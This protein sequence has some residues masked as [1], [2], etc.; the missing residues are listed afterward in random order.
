M[1][2]KRVVIACLLITAF[3]SGIA[4]AD[5]PVPET[6]KIGL[7]FGQS[8]ANIFTLGSET[9]IDI[10]T[11]ENGGYKSLLEVKSPG[12]IKVRRDEY[13]NII[14]GSE[15][16]IDYVRAAKYEG[17]V[18]GP[19]HIQIGGV[20]PDTAAA[21]QV[22]KQVSS[23][24]PSA[25]LA[26]EGGWKVWSQLYLD[27][28]ECLEQI[29]VMQKEA[30]DIS[31][32]VVH[33][34][35][36]RIQIINS[37][38]GQLILLLNSEDK[39]KVMPKEAQGKV[40][41]LQYKGKKYRG[42][43]TMQSLPESDVTLIN[44]LPFDQYLYSVVPS[45]MPASWHM[46]ALKAQAVAA[47]NYAL[48]TMG[49]HSAYGFDLCATEHCQAYNG[50]AQENSR[51]TEA[52]DATGGKIITY[53]G[54]L[55]STFFHSSSGGH[56]EDSENVWGTKTD[57]IRGVDDKYSLGSP[58]DN[59]TVE[60]G[61][62]EIKEML[63]QSDIDLGEIRDIRV[64]ETSQYGR[65]T[66]LEISGTKETRVFEKEKIRSIIGTRL[67]KSICYNL[68]TDADIF[69]RSSL[70]NTSEQGRT[71]CMYVASASGKTTVKGSGNKISVKGMNGTKAYNVV[72]DKYTFDGKGFGHGL[73]M[74]QYGAKGM[75]EAGYNYQKILEY[76]YQGAK[77]Q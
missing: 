17:E 11:L 61:R 10:L 33:P 16:E 32:S 41:S 46:E 55:I 48:V 31:Y 40:S 66:R 53:N 58:Y 2:A 29:K 47:R 3:I 45:E 35:R 26:Y 70:F 76:Y 50:L 20:Y 37:T 39:V 52:V 69:V 62:D 21:M 18:I 63:A 77:V 30:G 59:W 73:G 65:V 24:T 8:Q 49:R 5:I 23:I 56:T 19:Y 22:L 44:E 74:S 1:K 15:C 13:Y 75:A 54:A 7:S 25:F 42:S 68:K 27:E 38:T 36:K 60:L 72:P 71:S 4:H 9:G 12:D 57:Y 64:L 6:I 51:T 43:I 14:N 28:S 34:D 67:L